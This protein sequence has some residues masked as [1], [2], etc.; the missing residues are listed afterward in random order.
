MSW[1][2]VGGLA[3][4]AA[5]TGLKAAQGAR[6]R[7]DAER[8][9]NLYVDPGVQRNYGLERVSN[10]LGQ[11]YNNF[12]LPG[13]SAMLDNIRSGQASTVAQG[14]NAATSSNDILDLVTR[15]QSVADNATN[16]L[17]LQNAAGK[18]QA[19]QSYLNSINAV[20]QDQVRV[21]QELNNRFSGRQQE[22]AALEGA[23]IQNQY[24]AIN[25]ALSGINTLYSTNFVGRDYVNQSTGKMERMPSVWDSYW[26]KKKGA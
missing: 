1:V 21:N 15:S 8:I 4:T 12:N 9:R 20:G 17:Y 24:N 2:A 10:I 7:R 18:Q 14:V 13:F 23:G 16:D 3:I 6:Q 19:L 11:N 25:E 22:S 26:S 5:G